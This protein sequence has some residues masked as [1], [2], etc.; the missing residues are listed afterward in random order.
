MFYE[1]FLN[2][3]K[4]DMTFIPE[5]ASFN[6]MS[7]FTDRA[8]QDAYNEAAI[9]ITGQESSIFE[10]IMNEAEGDSDGGNNAEVSK[11]TKKS[12]L[13]TVGDFFGWLWG[14]IKGFFQTIADKIKELFNKA[15]LAAGK[16]SAKDFNEALANLPKDFTMK[17]KFRLITNEDKLMKHC[18]DTFNEVQ[19][20][21]K[22]AMDQ[23]QWTDDA[24]E[25]KLKEI[26]QLDISYSNAKKKFEDLFRSSPVVVKKSEIE[27]NKKI[28]SDYVFRPDGW[29]KEIGDLYDATKKALDGDMKSLKETINKS[30]KKDDATKLVKNKLSIVKAKN[31]QF[32]ALTSLFNA[33]KKKIRAVAISI[34]AK[35]LVAGKVKKEK[36]KKESANESF[37]FDDVN[38]DSLRESFRYSFNEEAEEE[39]DFTDTEETDVEDISDDDVNTESANLYNALVAYLS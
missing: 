2:S 22:F 23:A 35:V 34:V 27:S 12:L 7:I 3:I 36:E 8:L 11:E 37:L 33:G 17:A 1:N 20:T 10:S 38:K 15:V 25:T 30:K 19:K 13:K 14:K 26:E 32:T 28:I 29:L 16:G 4:P 31:K 21:V 9:T 6:D 5:S 39:L 24:T 18:K